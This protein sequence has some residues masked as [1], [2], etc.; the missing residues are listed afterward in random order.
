MLQYSLPQRQG[1]TI[2]LELVYTTNKVS[3]CVV[4]LGGLK[5]KKGTSHSVE[6][7]INHNGKNKIY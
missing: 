3:A 4:H 1:Y 2:E 7:T 6:E 5:N